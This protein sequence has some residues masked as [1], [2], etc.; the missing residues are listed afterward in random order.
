MLK[1]ITKIKPNSEGVVVAEFGNTSYEF[2]GTPLA[3]EVMD[4]A[5]AVHL[6]Q[7][8]HFFPADLADLADTQH[9]GSLSPLSPL[10]AELGGNAKPATAKPSGQTIVPAPAQEHEEENADEL[11]NGGLPLE[12]LTPVV[13]RK[14]A[15]K[16]K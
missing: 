1:L 10:F 14:A 15:R 6:I 7:T 11:I 2:K 9:I 5:H 12:A 13:T 3:C 8:N 16:A 4:H